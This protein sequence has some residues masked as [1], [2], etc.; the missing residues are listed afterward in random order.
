VYNI[1]MAVPQE[2]KCPLRNGSF[3]SSGPVPDSITGLSYNAEKVSDTTETGEADWRTN[4]SC[5][6]EG[7]GLYAQMIVKRQSDES[8]ALRN[9]AN[10]L[11]SKCELREMRNG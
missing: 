8:G 2:A 11:S 4:M 6:V 9:A 10:G 1:G 5:S 7:C 3:P